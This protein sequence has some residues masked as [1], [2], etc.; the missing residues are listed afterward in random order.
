MR[1]AEEE[2]EERYEDFL[3]SMTPL[4]RI[5]HFQMMRGRH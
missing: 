1:E 2:R 3:D 5:S 4:Q